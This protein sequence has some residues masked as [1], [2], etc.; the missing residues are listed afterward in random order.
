[1]SQVSYDGQSTPNT[2]IVQG[3]GLPASATLTLS[4]AATGS[5]GMS[6][7]GPTDAN[8]NISATIPI[9]DTVIQGFL[10]ELGAGQW[11]DPS[12][13]W[14]VAAPDISMTCSVAA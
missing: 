5:P 3:A 2:L 8:G 4:I 6:V 14:F 1:M 7:S 9:S 13:K 11:N 12:N 10:P